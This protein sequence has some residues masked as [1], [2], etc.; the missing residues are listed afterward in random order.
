MSTAAGKDFNVHQEDDANAVNENIESSEKNSKGADESSTS[1]L[2]LDWVNLG[3]E[4]GKR[5]SEQ[6]ERIHFPSDVYEYSIETTTEELVIV[7]THGLKITHMGK[8][9]FQTCSSQTMKTLILR[10]HLIRLM[11]G[12]DGFQQLTTLELYDN[13]IGKIQN[14][15]NMHNAYD[16]SG[17]D[18]TTSPLSSASSGT[19]QTIYTNPGSTSS[20]GLPGGTLQIL[21]LSY[22]VI[23][24]MEPVKYCPNLVELCKLTWTSFRLHSSPI[25]V[26]KFTPFFYT[27][28]PLCCFMFPEQNADLANNKIKD[29]KG[30]SMLSKLRK[31]DLG[32]NRIRVIPQSI[33]GGDEEEELPK[34]LEELWLGKNK[35]EMIQG[36]QNLT[37]LKRLD[38]QANRLTTVEGLSSQVDTL[39]ELYL[40]HNAIDNPGGMWC[41]LKRNTECLFLFYDSA[42]FVHFLLP[43]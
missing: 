38:V 14:L 9:L 26:F 41:T 32:A 12:L 10:S 15:N 25:F 13:Q 30:L 16:T 6:Q 33:A 37:N 4:L 28:T 18:N 34:S 36:L 35:I 29:I 42:I 19:S 5:S 40:S 43:P 27:L 21:D 11:E 17:P 22:N 24:D 7:G 8:D 2:P 23:R 20:Y 1:R 39:E 31:V 3:E